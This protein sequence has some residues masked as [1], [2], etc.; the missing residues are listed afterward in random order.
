M[1]KNKKKVP[2]DKFADELQKALEE[3]SDYVD[4]TVVV[5]ATQQTAEETAQAIASAAPKKTG[6]YAASITS[7]PLQRKGH[8]YKEV[9][10]ANAPHFRLTHLL[11]RSHALRNGGRTRPFPHWAKGEAGVVDKLISHIKEGLQ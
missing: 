9:V 1:A 2:I 6:A 3:F 7:G 4:S 11:E 8:V 5:K 10:Y